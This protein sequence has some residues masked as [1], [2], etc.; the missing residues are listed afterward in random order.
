[1]ERRRRRR[2]VGTGAGQQGYGG[3]HNSVAVEFDTALNVPLSDPPALHVAV[4]SAGN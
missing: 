1:M 3:L 2:R 4:M